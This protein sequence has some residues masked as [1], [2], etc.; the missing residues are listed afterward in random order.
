[1]KILILH[2]HFNTP[3]KGGAIRSYYLAKA[4]V[5]RGIET[6]VISGC[7]E[8][9]YKFENVEG[10]AV[11]YLPVAYDNSF[12]F[13]ARSFSFIDYI[14]KSVRLAKK[15]KGI[16]VC[17]AMSVPLT[18]GLAAYRLKAKM[19]IP[20]VFEVGDLWPDAPVQMGFVKNYFFASLLYRLEKFI[21]RE[22]E[23]IV[24]LSH[25][26]K[27]AIE[28]KI[29]TKKIHIISN[30]SDCDF[31]QPETKDPILEA[32]YKTENKLVVSYVGAL[33]VANG[34]DYFIE[35][36]HA[37]RKANLAV[38]FI[39]C[40]QGAL[41]E[42]LKSSAEKLNLTNLI[43]T[44]A[45]NRNTVRGILNVTDVAF[46]CYKNVP[47]LET[48]SPNKYFDA[49]AAGK[50]IVTNFGGWIKDEIEKNNCGFSVN[51]NQPTDFVKKIE[52]FLSSRF[53]LRPYQQAARKLAEEKY[54]RSTLSNQFA[55]IFAKS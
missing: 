29:S 33:G 36:A 13:I 28:K 42:H 54:N 52:P 16:D 15:I 24:A 34:L 32:K 23:S 43:F 19:K 17:Y 9:K 5:D 45:V 3:E 47:I 44:G 53:N 6:V 25:P 26:I 37:S 18:I 48:G 7:N 4:L 55:D 21:Y 11:H 8:K 41:F 31:Y 20:F 38:Q 35:C 22:A 39:L 30:F 46:I 2:Q 1:M 50:L 51:P 49:L 27:D 12:G 40:G 10:I 14:F